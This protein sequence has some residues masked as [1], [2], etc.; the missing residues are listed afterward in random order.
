MS[1]L[2]TLERHPWN[3]GFHWERRR[4]PFRRLTRAQADQFD[5]LGF[6]VVEDVVDPITLEQ[7]TAEIDGF[8]FVTTPSVRFGVEE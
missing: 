3:V 7:V 6:V 8:D 4:G 5:E 2:D 1:A